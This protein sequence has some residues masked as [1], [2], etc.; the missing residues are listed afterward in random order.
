MKKLLLLLLPVLVAFVF[1][2]LPS[3]GIAQTTDGDFQN[4][5]NQLRDSRQVFKDV[6]AQEK[7][8]AA[9]VSRAKVEALRAAA[10]QR[11]AEAQKR[12]ED[13][14]KEILLKLVDIQVKWMARV[15]ARVQ[16]MPNIPDELKNKLIGEVDTAI[17]NLNAE[18]VKIQSA[19][20]RDE[21]KALAKEVRDLFK[22]KQEVVKNIVEAIH[23]SGANAAVARAE[24]R[25]AAMKARVQELKD[26][27][28]NTNE[29]ESDLADAGEDLNNA[30]GAI[31]R[32]AFKE[33]NED[34][35]GVYQKFRE[36]AQK[37]KGLQ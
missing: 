33:A 16:K 3:V 21:I 11:R 23:A 37:A 13:K 20:G 18:R 8:D 5:L 34:L 35:K 29:V 10:E 28:K 6:K 26:S 15:I 1:A 31:G 36:I 32:K 14:R 22:S 7:S 4:A 27:G 2:G 19:S 25:V 24:E 9:E 17:Q 30:Q 12:M